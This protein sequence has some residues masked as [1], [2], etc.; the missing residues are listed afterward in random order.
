MDLENGLVFVNVSHPDEI[1]AKDTQRT[2][3][4]RAMRDIGRSRR[5]EKRPPALT[6]SW[7]P[8]SIS[9]AVSLESNP[10][11]VELDPRARELIHF[12]TA[13]H[14][15]VSLFKAN[16][17]AVHAE[18]DYHYRPF[19]TVWFTMSLHDHSAFRL[20]MANAAMFLAEKHRPQTFRYEDCH[21]ALKYYGQCVRQITDRLADPVDSTSEG[22]VT[23][24]LGLICHDVCLCSR[25]I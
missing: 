23:T 14:P 6:F 17:Y 22:V 5:R 16:R 18:A 12:S 2:I 3:R 25:F 15:L 10:L 8:A 7:Q 13:V 19:R 21:E 11:P 20:A 9:P 1:H 24:I 4:R